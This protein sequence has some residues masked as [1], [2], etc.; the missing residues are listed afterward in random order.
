[1][2]SKAGSGTPM[3][4]VSEASEETEAEQIAARLGCTSAWS[5]IWRQGDADDDLTRLRKFGLL[6]LWA[7]RNTSHLALKTAELGVTVCWQQR[8]PIDRR[9]YHTSKETAVPA[10]SVQGRAA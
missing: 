3:P 7:L 9:I 10:C 2:D 4:G 5:T 6:G 1:M 8:C